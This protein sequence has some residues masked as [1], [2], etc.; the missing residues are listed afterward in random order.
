VSLPAP[1]LAAGDFHLFGRLFGLSVFSV[2]DAIGVP[3][4]WPN[5]PP[6]KRRG[7]P[8]MRNA[9][10]TAVHTTDDGIAISTAGALCGETYSAFQ[11]DNADLRERVC[12]VLRVGARA[13]DAAAAPI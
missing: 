10:I 5:V 8:D 7:L 6:C 4:S 2:A 11:I 9:I 1:V 13:H 12:R 3:E